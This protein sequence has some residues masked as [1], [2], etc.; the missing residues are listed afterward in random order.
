VLGTRWLC[1]VLRHPRFVAMLAAVTMT[2][3]GRSSE[4]PRYDGRWYI[5]PTTVRIQGGRWSQEWAPVDGF[6]L[7]SPDATTSVLHND[8]FEMTI[9][10]HPRSPLP[11]R[12]VL[13]DVGRSAKRPKMSRRW[14]ASAGHAARTTDA[15]VSPRGPRS[16]EH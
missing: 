16:R 2:G 3:H 1:E 15:G 6:E 14:R 7:W 4:W 10:R 5:A 12:P 11:R 13:C 8:R 9:F